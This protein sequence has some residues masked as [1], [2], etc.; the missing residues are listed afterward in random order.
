MRNINIKLECVYGIFKSRVIMINEKGV[1]VA[2]PKVT[3]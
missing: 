2:T 1:A 3:E